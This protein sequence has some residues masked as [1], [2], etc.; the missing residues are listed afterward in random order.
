[1]L[2]NE[3]IDKVINIQHPNE[4]VNYGSLFSSIKYKNKENDRYNNYIKNKNAMLLI[5]DLCNS[6]QFNSYVDVINYYQPE[7]VDELRNFMNIHYGSYDEY[8][9]ISPSAVFDDIKQL[10]DNNN[11]KNDE[12]N[13]FKNAFVNNIIKK[14]Y[15]N[16]YALDIDVNYYSWIHSLNFVY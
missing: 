16:C 7:T 4:D 11:K 8:Y 10:L 2:F 1:M 14:K 5:N 15:Y 9:Y 13:E 6:E 12:I 3:L